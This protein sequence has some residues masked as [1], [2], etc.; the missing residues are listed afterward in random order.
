[1]VRRFAFQFTARSTQIHHGDLHGKAIQAYQAPKYDDDSDSDREKQNPLLKRQ[2]A[3]KPSYPPDR[4]LLLE[5]ISLL[6]DKIP[7]ISTGKKCC[8]ESS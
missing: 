3:I 6:Y 8:S 7:L 4:L 1:M 2:R 5:I